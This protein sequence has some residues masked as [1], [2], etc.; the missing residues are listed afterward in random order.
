MPTLLIIDDSDSA[1]AEIKAVVEA[2]GIFDRILE[3]TDGYGGLRQ[4]LSESYDVVVCDLEMRGFDGEKL[5]RAKESRPGGGN[6]PFIV[7]TACE[8]PDR[9]TRLLERGAS[10][11]IGKPFHGPEIVARLQLH[12]KIK[13]L[14]DELMVKNE[15]LAKLSTSDAVT[16][17]RNRRY[18][19]EILNV[20]FLRA[21][22]YESPLAVI[23]M[24]LDHFK[25][26]N[27][28]YGHLAGDA[29]LKGVSQLLL[30]HLRATDVGGRFGGEELLA[31]LHQCSAEA[32]AVVAE[33]VRGSIEDA[34]F[35]APDGRS[36][37]VTLSLGIAEYSAE[38]ASAGALLEA[39]DRALYRAKNE[40]RNRIAIYEA[41]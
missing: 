13:Q 2:G 38:M 9:R 4:I 18:V 25:A 33:R 3:A 41:P 5:L 17:L 8:N 23:M 24:D 21:R 11:V 29:V 1:R 34:V 36:V 32:A 14:Q 40:G 15:T 12:L 37:Q 39:A 31:V 7:V 22:R 30:E 16:G 28:T 20:E 26:V 19:S 6:I 35:E 10:D 27:D